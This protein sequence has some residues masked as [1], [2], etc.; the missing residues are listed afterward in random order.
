ESSA[1]SSAFVEVWVWNFLLLVV[2]LTMPNTQDI[3]SRVAGSLSKLSYDRRDTFWPGINL[4]SG[5]GWKAN[6][7][8]ALISAILFVAGVLTLSQ[9]SEFLYFQF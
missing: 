6:T 3:F 7:R 1:G 5:I 4:V 9:V 8:W 2:V